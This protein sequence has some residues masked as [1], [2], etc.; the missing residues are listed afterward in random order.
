MHDAHASATCA[1]ATGVC[2]GSWPCRWQRRRRWHVAAAAVASQQLTTG[3]SGSSAAR[4][5]TNVHVH[6]ERQLV[7]QVDEPVEELGPV[8]PARQAGAVATVTTS[9]FHGSGRQGA[10]ERNQQWCSAAEGRKHGV[11][12]QA[13]LQGEHHNVVTDDDTPWVI[14]VLFSRIQ[15]NGIYIN[16]RRTARRDRRPPW[17]HALSNSSACHCQA[18]AVS[19]SRCARAPR[20]SGTAAPS[21]S[22][23]R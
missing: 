17:R 12:E 23:T 10:S 2:A 9:T 3:D 18:A 19:A 5:L 6:C 22:P 14:T 4:G 11:C 21:R 20:M 13:H 15:L 8:V 7:A 1:G 16:K